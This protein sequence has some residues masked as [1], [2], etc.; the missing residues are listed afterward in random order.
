MPFIARIDG[1]I[2]T[3]FEA[4]KT[5]LAE[6]PRCGNQ[7]GIRDSHNRDG[8]FVARHFWHPTTPPEGCSGGSSGESAEHRRMK[9]IAAS[10]AKVVFA[11]ATVLLEHSVNN[12][13]ADVLVKFNQPHPHF[14]TGLAI[15]VQHEHRSKDIEAERRE[16]L[17]DLNPDAIFIDE[18]MT[19]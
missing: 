8:A 19:A 11:D 16:V 7:L 13:R 18:S 3:P 17:R 14:G 6:C 15:E 5:D 12:R 10:K 4:D 9:S 2:C 1:E